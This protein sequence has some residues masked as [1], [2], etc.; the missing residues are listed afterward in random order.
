MYVGYQEKE[1]I[2]C[3]RNEQMERG[4]F[5]SAAGGG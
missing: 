4:T 2:P 3:R 1:L 5:A